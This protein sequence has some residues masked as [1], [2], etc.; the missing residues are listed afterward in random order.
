MA[1]RIIELPNDTG[2]WPL[3]V[4]FQCELPH[5]ALVAIEGGGAIEMLTGAITR[6]GFANLLIA[7][8]FGHR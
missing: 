4:C 3:A 5:D 1:C 8:Q 2:P 7:S 6:N